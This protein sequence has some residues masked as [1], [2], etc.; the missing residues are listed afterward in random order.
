M[1]RQLIRIS[2]LQSSK[3]VTALYALLGVLYSVAGVLMIVLGGEQLF[4]IGVIYMSM[5]VLMAIIGFIGFV[6][7]AALYNWLA[8][9][10]GGFE[11]EV[12]E[13]SQY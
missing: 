7:F 2:I 10:L 1:K 4:V 8:S 13:V 5:P 11:Y 6:I 12:T 9:I 3:I